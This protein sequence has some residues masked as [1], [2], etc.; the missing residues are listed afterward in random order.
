MGALGKQNTQIVSLERPQSTDSVPP[1]C[2]PQT[3]CAE[4]FETE[5]ATD[6]RLT[7]EVVLFEP[8]ADMPRRR[9]KMAHRI[10]HSTLQRLV[11]L[12][13]E[14]CQIRVQPGTHGGLIESSALAG[15]S[16]FKS[17]TAI[18]LNGQPLEG[19]QVLLAITAA[20]SLR[21]AV[22]S[23]NQRL[24]TVEPTA[25]V[26]EG[27]EVG[28]TAVAAHL[29]VGVLCARICHPLWHRSGLVSVAVSLSLSLL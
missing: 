7:G 8:I 28:V 9:R 20:P 27:Q 12:L 24:S 22:L 25:G 26:E 6:E 2:N 5:P 13:P 16:L 10:D 21:S 23:N 17:L 15:F 14:T 3:C 1:F 18:N 4:P 19:G 29:E 11:N